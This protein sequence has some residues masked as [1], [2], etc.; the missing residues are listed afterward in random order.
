MTEIAESTPSAPRTQSVTTAAAGPGRQSS[1]RVFFSSPSTI[2]LLAV[3]FAM[4]VFSFLGPLVSQSPSDTGFTVLSPPNGAN[5]AGTDSLGRDLLSRLMIGGQVS[6]F[7][8][9]AVAVICLTVA[10]T[11]GGLAGFYGGVADAVLSRVSEF[12][13]VIPGIILALVAVAMLGASLPL[14]IVILSLTM[15]PGVARIVRAECMRIAELG[16]VESSRA[17][18]F[19]PLRILWSDVLPNAF[20]PVLVATTM[21]I[22]RAI[23]AESSLAFLGLGDANAPSWG[24]L[25]YEA[26]A[27][28]QSAWWLTVFPGVAIFIV[29]LAANLLGDRL[30]DSLNPTLSRVK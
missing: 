19:R 5:L 27:Y 29:V 17:A 30:N 26:Q 25:L 6:L 15:W 10:V 12:F 13:Q 1:A 8:G 9:A 20:P 14:I 16:Y 18:G 28:M 7:V 22:G 4:V 21:T 11:I 24:A 3:L 2:V 23:L